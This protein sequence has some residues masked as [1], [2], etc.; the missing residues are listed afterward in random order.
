MVSEETIYLREL[1]E[2][3]TQARD[4]LHYSFGKCVEIGNKDLYSPDEQDRF[5]ALTAKF[6][7][8]SDL[9]IKQ[10]IKLIDILDLDEP[11]E[12]IRDAI[13]RAEKKGL[14]ASASEFVEIRKLRN[15]IAHEYAESH[16]DIL[17][18]YADVLRTTPHL[19]QSVINILEYCRKFEV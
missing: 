8:L 11:P 3:L 18:I 10:A 7:R 9:I 13:N 16:E 19:F 17:E 5:E 12:T 14:I 1:L 2:R 15:R 6:A 4:T